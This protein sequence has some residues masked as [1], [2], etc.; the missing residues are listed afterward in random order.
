[1][2]RKW[3]GRSVLNVILKIVKAVTKRIPAA[4]A[5]EMKNMPASVVL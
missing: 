4:V 1:M 2:Y 3:K 5:Y